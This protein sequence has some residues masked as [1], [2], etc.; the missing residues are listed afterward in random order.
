MDTSGCLCPL[1]V[2]HNHKCFLCFVLEIYKSDCP[3]SVKTIRTIQNQQSSQLSG[4]LRLQFLVF[5]IRK[6]QTCQQDKGQQRVYK[7]QAG[8]VLWTSYPVE[9]SSSSRC[10]NFHKP[11]RPTSQV[12]LKTGRS[13]SS[14]FCLRHSQ[15]SVKAP[16]SNMEL[17]NL[18]N[19]EDINIKLS[20][21]GLHQDRNPY[22]FSTF[23]VRQRIY[24]QYQCGNPDI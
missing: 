2:E 14:G 23:L 13:G 22:I 16:W 3:Q 17:L 19:S 5:R 21:S 20:S 15:A 11:N 9:M 12:D 24:F 7:T 8:S 1:N 6:F 10:S 18:E 4:D